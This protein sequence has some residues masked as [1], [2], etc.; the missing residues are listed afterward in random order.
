MIIR[1]LLA[2]V[3]AVAMTASADE[4]PYVVHRF[5]GVTV[6]SSLSSKSQIWTTAGNTTWFAAYTT[7]QT[8]EVF[9]TDGTPGGTVQLTFGNGSPHHHWQGPFVGSVQGKLVYGGS[10]PETGGLYALD[11]E[12]GAPV[13][14]ARLRPEDLTAGV[15]RDGWLYFTARPRGSSHFL[16][17]RTDGTAAG[18]RQLSAIQDWSQKAPLYPFGDAIV[19]FARSTQGAGLYSIAPDGA[20]TLLQPFDA[21][22]L[23]SVFHVQTLGDRL[24]FMLLTGGHRRVWTS[25]GTAA[26]TR[27]IADLDAFRPVGAVGDR[28]FFQG[29]D[30]IL[31]STDGTAEGTHVT[32]LVAGTDVHSIFPG[33]VSGGRLFFYVARS[34]A[35]LTTTLYATEGSA[36]TTRPVLSAPYG[37]LPGG[38]FT[39]GDRYYFSH[40]DGIH[41]QELWRTD[42]TA[43]EMVADLDP[44][45][46]SGLG[47]EDLFAVRPDGTAVL[48]GARRDT[49]T[50]PWITDG[51][52]GGTRILANLAPEVPEHASNP[53]NLRASG[54]RLFL[55]VSLDEGVAVA[56]SDGTSRGTSA[57]L[58]EENRPIDWAVAANGRYFFRTAFSGSNSWYATDGTAASLTRIGAAAPMVSL[59]GGVFFRGASSPA[60]T[61]LWFSDGT[62]AGTRLFGLFSEWVQM[63]EAGDVAWIEDRQRLWISDGT[64]AGTLEVTTAEPRIGGIVRVV[65]AGATHFLLE[66]GASGMR[67]WR[68]DGTPAGTRIVMAK[69]EPVDELHFAGATAGHAYF[70]FNRRLY[71][72]DGTA[73]GTVELP[74][75]GHACMSA[76]ALGDT[77]VFASETEDE[78]ALW[79]SDG[80]AA[81][82]ARL[83]TFEGATCPDIVTH[84]ERVYFSGDDPE[85]GW[86]LW[87]SDGTIAGTRLFADLLPG[88]TSSSPADLTATEDHLFFAAATPTGRELWAVGG[89][90]TPTRRRALR[91]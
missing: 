5:S 51:T 40:D 86:E 39:I 1:S 27:V 73:E 23:R 85:H 16:L 35:S 64:D 45:P 21:S 76:G 2:A 61:E 11:A 8:L 77:F 91:P 74:V 3:F 49:G 18:T 22:V 60:G 26:G 9:R 70:L 20:T 29:P 53:A 43:S 38:G 55:T 56:V 84:G 80:T 30:R 62:L 7:P 59:R 87:A 75:T 89:R 33:A 34:G 28:L 79:R 14:L 50:E 25:D 81:G 47:A 10:D 66:I 17:W 42:G 58:L 88:P 90:R 82:T 4:L 37:K 41:G 36:A 57:T 71:G 83:R 12:G 78:W 44:G 15:Q 69:A 31:W 13:L 24:L 54:N 48:A 32:D 46:R 52:A 19:F 67:L 68:S 65:R 63:L 6:Q 72:S